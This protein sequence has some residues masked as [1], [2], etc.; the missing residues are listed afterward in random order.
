MEFFRKWIDIFQDIPVTK[1]SDC[2]IWYL[3]S[4]KFPDSKEVGA[5]NYQNIKEKD[6]EWS[7]WILLG[8]LSKSL[9]PSQEEVWEVLI[10]KYSNAYQQIYDLGCQSISKYREVLWRVC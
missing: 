8:F 10:S 4:P 3:A 9:V 1:N 6:L 2:V 7:S 5:N